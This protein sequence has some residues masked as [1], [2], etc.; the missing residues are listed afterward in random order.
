MVQKISTDAISDSGVTA[1]KLAT[2][3]VTQAKVAAGVAG[4]GPAFR[5]NASGTTSCTATNNKIALAAE[6]FDTATCFDTT[7][8]RFTP[9]VA[10]YYQINGAIQFASNTYAVR[11]A[12]YKNG[13]VYSYGVAAATGVSATVGCLVYMNGT[14]DY[15][16]LFGY[17]A[18]TQNAVAGADLT[19]L[20]GFLARAA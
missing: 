1:V 14:T 3:S 2:D 17:S 6:V 11:A 8:S 16:E 15:V 12:I 20:D 19:Y 13:S 9:N 10:G 5:A 18:T 4:E 7:N